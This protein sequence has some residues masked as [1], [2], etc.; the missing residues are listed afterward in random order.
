ML[1]RLSFPLACNGVQAGWYVFFSFA[2]ERLVPL[3][4]FEMHSAN[5]LVGRARRGSQFGGRTDA[6]ITD[7]GWPIRPQAAAPNSAAVV[8]CKVLNDQSRSLDRTRS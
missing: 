4:H 8:V 3:G 5:A 6:K 7:I 1:M 2:D